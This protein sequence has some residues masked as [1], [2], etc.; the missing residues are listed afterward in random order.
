MPRSDHPTNIREPWDL[1]W[2]EFDLILGS[3]PLIDSQHMQIRTIQRASAL[4]K[5]CGLNLNV[6]SQRRHSER[7]LGEAMH[8]LRHILMSPEER[9]RFPVPIDLQ[10][11]DDMRRLLVMASDL[12]PQNHYA[13]VWA[14]AI[15]KIVH[16]VAGLEFSGMLD[17]L[18]LAR[19]QIFRRITKHLKPNPGVSSSGQTPSESHVFLHP[20]GELIGLAHIDWKEEK[21]RSSL[22]LKLIH[23][24]ETLVDEV[25]DYIG[26]RFVL[27]NNHEIPLLLDALIRNDIVIPHLVIT[28][29]SRNTLVD[30]AKGKK[31]LRLAKDLATH[32]ELT[33]EEYLESRRHVDWSP[34]AKRS[35]NDRSNRFSSQQ[36][37]SLQLTVRHLV[38][39][40]NPAHRVL[41]ALSMQ[42]DHYQQGARSSNL[43]ETLVPEENI[44]FFPLEI[45]IMD[46]PSYED[47]KFGPSSHEK[48]KASQLAAARKRIL[49]PLL[50]MHPSILATQANEKITL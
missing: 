42:L 5:G 24:S 6:P 8:F 33:P 50:D 15:L 31:I 16:A 2:Q 43:L 46:L 14:C 21:S 1:A 25:F 38:R 47:S 19:R 23:K 20:S 4:L 10:D 17:D 48:Y 45:Q 41:S 18:P 37:R 26:V 30:I 32:G 49:S 3:Q 29:R 34:E 39:L 28:P 44:R 12:R 22:I 40:K 9:D 36:Y 27:R 35:G 13:R 11:C 7:L